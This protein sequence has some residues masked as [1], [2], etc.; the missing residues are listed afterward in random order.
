[1]TTVHA[2]ARRNFLK[3]TALAA[4][5]AALP[6]IGFSQASTLA[7]PVERKF[8]PQPGNWRTFE[9]TTRVDIAKPQGITRVW[10]PIPSVNT[11][12]QKSLE[13]S[14]S[15]NGKTQ[16]TA[17]QHDGARMLYV[18]FAE[19]EAQPFVEL[20]SRIQTQNRAVD[21][22]QKQNTIEDAATL[23]YWTRPT[24]LLPTHGI[25][26]KTAQEAIRGARTDVEKTQRLYDWIIANTFREPKVRGCGEGDIWA[27]NVPT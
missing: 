18:E 6:V 15:S 5:S 10:L 12:W 16:L 8:A 3:Q 17:D 1:M 26:R 25:V 23:T 11:E 2:L 20:C 27:A 4:A 7:A 19:N 21:W 14:F 24:R 9:V 13:S 22:T